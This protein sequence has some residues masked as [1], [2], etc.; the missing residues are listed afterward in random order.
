MDKKP[1]GVTVA[2]LVFAITA[3]VTLYTGFTMQTTLSATGAGLM[4]GGEPIQDY[5]LLNS[6]QFALGSLGGMGMIIMGI[7]FLAVTWFLWNKNA[8][9]WYFAVGLLGVGIII[10]IVMMLFYGVQITNVGFVAIG[11][12]VLVL[13]ALFHEDT[14]SAV[15]PEIDYKGWNTK[16]LS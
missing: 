13:L 11:L 16:S 14:I 9:A 1:L 4:A 3:L 10:D 5:L 12:S 8:L 6:E 15:K 2:C 7:L